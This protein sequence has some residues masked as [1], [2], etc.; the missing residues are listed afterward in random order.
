MT[1]RLVSLFSSEP[2]A[3]VIFAWE[4]AW[5]AGILVVAAGIAHLLAGRRRVLVRSAIWHVCLVGLLLLPIV[6]AS[7]PRMAVAVLDS[8]PASAVVDVPIADDQLVDPVADADPP[9]APSEREAI[10]VLE[11]PEA[12]LPQHIADA[13]SNVPAAGSPGMPVA[14][15]R[16]SQGIAAIS[17]V[18]VYLLV[19][20]GF[21][22]RLAL[23]LA[24]VAALRRSGAAVVNSAWLGGLEHWRATIGIR[25]PV[26]LRETAEVTVPVV[27]GGR[28]PAI[29]LPMALAQSTDRQVIDAVLV[30][31][32]T[33]VARGDYAWN[34]LLRVVQALYWLH[35][36]VWLAARVVRQVREDA[37]DA[38]CVHWMG[39]VRAY[40]GILVDVAAGLTRH[41]EVVLGMAM[42]RSSRLSRRL[43]RIENSRGST[44]GLL[45]RRARL[46]IAVL[47]AGIV[48]ILGAVRLVRQASATEQDPVPKSNGAHGD[49]GDRPL[50]DKPAAGSAATVVD[51]T[52]GDT[53]RANPPF[54]KK[55]RYTKGAPKANFWIDPETKNEYFVTVPGSKN[56]P[57]DT[58]AQRITAVKVRR[59]KI[60]KTV[61][62]RVS[63]EAYGQVSVRLR[64][65][66]II[67]KAPVEVGDQVKAGQVLAELDVPDID[68][69]IADKEAA[70]AQAEGAEEQ[71]RAGVESAEAGLAAHEANVLGARAENEK[72]ASNE[73]FRKIQ[74]ERMKKLFDAKSI[75][76][77]ILEENEEQF[78]A[79]VA[80]TKSAEAKVQTA[81][82]ELRKGKVA[83]RVAMA[84]LKTAVLETAAAKADLGRTRS[85][86]TDAFRLVRSPI[87]G[88][89][90]E[91][92]AEEDM[93]VK[94]GDG[95]PLY[96]LAATGFITAVVQLLEADAVQVKRD[97]PAR[98]E[99]DALP[100]HK[101]VTG[102]VTRV[103]YAMI[104]GTHV[105]R[106]EITIPNTD[107]RLK[108]GLTGSS[109]IVFGEIE[110]GLSLPR[111][112]FSRTVR[113]KD[114]AYY[115]ECFHVVDGRVDK[116]EVKVGYIEPNT[117][118]G[119]VEILDGLK[120]GDEVVLSPPRGLQDGQSVEAIPPK[121]K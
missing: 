114:G 91:K 45:G 19:V 71:A 115:M 96:R 104:P 50:E 54:G 87:D 43:A 98:V 5:K 86:T 2:T 30:H 101:P 64:N 69:E 36:V 34:L 108:P 68:T 7:G 20:A 77:A 113:S 111:S 59:G 46:G 22:I 51:E 3:V 49:A 89:V 62:A 92:N 65:A 57:S 81:T 11:A 16:N 97:N 78:E 116:V 23:S 103:S 110:D 118:Y 10:A 4:V 55:R 18:V 117:A 67:S 39:D 29:L 14:I 107:G 8:V 41:S 75:D 85:M 72:A 35:P 99:I 94:P 82:A 119:R 93:S 80:A 109:R 31:E 38:V 58:R 83:V 106:A 63:L 53:K 102:K 27:I 121:K 100:N 44:R 6:V 76:A 84:A 9:A 32:L 56:D 17:A 28:K 1:A 40:C 79:A 95:K 15:G 120:E 73:K 74:Y 48:A 25:P 37:C 24:A 21:L 112:A 33:H 90:L 47:F 60:E 52:P 26:A 88:V 70:L 105:Y 13:P 66:G 12:A 61:I 42:T